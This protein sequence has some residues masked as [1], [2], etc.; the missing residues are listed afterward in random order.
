MA[1]ERE[2][3][4]ARIENQTKIQISFEYIRCTTKSPTNVTIYCTN[5]LLLTLES[6]S[7]SFSFPLSLLS[8]VKCFEFHYCLKH[9]I[10]LLLR[11]CMIRKKKHEKQLKF[12]WRNNFFLI[13]F[14]KSIHTAYDYIELCFA[15]ESFPHL[16]FD[17][18]RQIDHFCVVNT[19][20]TVY[21]QLFKWINSK[22][23]SVNIEQ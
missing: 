17:S 20:C 6:L 7:L 5:F 12:N 3:K 4:K 11:R 15:A 18:I 19:F 13:I 1:R 9:L 16:K 10:Q 22:N 14:G 2:R 21:F 8:L 23:S